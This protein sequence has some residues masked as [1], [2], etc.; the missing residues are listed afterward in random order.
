MT[1]ENASINAW[2]AMN[3]E[4][5]SAN[6]SASRTTAAYQKPSPRKQ[7]A[8]EAS[9]KLIMQQ[10]GINHSKQQKRMNQVPSW[11]IPADSNE[12]ISQEMAYEP[13]NFGEPTDSSNLPSGAYYGKPNFFRKSFPILKLFFSNFRNPSLHRP[14][15][16]ESDELRVATYSNCWKR[17]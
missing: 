1:S 10:T 12:T 11:N 17:V 13:M 8:G 7:V 15:H 5:P 4:M 3:M 2:P 6:P 16:R 9:M 14:S